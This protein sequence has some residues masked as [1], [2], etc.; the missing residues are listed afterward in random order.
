M[1]FM[2]TFPSEKVQKYSESEMNNI[3]NAQMNLK[4]RVNQRR[5]RRK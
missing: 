1:R 3:D 5:R 2:V 4:E